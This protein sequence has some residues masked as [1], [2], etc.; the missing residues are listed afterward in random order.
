MFKVGIVGA[1]MV[2][3]AIANAIA[4]R[5]VASEVLLVDLRPGRALAEAED[6]LHAT[7]FAHPVHVQAG[8][9]PQL[10]G[11]AVV[12][13]ACGVAQR[14][15]ETRLELLDRN[16]AVFAEVVPRVREAAPQALLLVVTNP[17]DIMT[18]VAW[19][20]SG[21]PPSRVFGSGTVLDTARFRA[22]LSVE[23]GVSPK[24]I[25]AYVLGE[26]GDSEVL[27]WQGATVGAV[28]LLRFAE[29]IGRPLTAAVRRRIEEEVRGAAYRIIAGKGATWYGVASAAA[30][31]LEAIRDDERAVLTLSSYTGE[32]RHLP[33][34][35][36]SL[37]RILG[38]DG[39]CGTVVPELSADERDA[40]GRS[41]EALLAAGEARWLAR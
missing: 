12:V 15:G 32:L 39:L 34:V 17:V 1:G 3:G 27:T 23:L 9:Y 20:L 30:R 19:R 40:L 25:H 14:P 26:H 8:D 33:P 35:V 2:G 18:L 38:R 31:I 13:L 21:L 4:L 29:S 7:P 36:L 41:A 28:P 10:A 5:G 6:V 24:S 11:A 16:A 22:L 37:P